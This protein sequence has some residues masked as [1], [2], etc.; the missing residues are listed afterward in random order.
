MV[1]LLTL[2]LHANVQ[3]SYIQRLRDPRQITAYITHRKEAALSS[4]R[5]GSLQEGLTAFYNS[6]DALICSAGSRMNHINFAAVIIASVHVWEAAKSDSN[7]TVWSDLHQR[8][9]QVYWQCIHGLQPLLADTAPQQISTVLWSSATLG[10]NPDDCVPGMVHALMHRFLQLINTTDARQRPNAQ[11]CANLIWAVATMRHPATEVL[12]AACS[13]F[14]SLLRSPIVK[15]HPKAEEV[16]SVVW[17]FGTL[18]QIPLDDALLKDLCAHMLTLL[19]SRDCRI[20]PNAQAISS[21]LWGLAELKHAP[22]HDVGSAMLDHLRALCKTPGWQPTSQAISNSLH[23][24]AEL[25]LDVTRV[26]GEALLNHLLGIPIAQVSDQHYSNVAW[27]LAVM[28]RL[29]LA[30]FDALLSRLSAKHALLVENSGLTTRHAQ[31]K[32]EEACQLHQAL[33]ALKPLQKPNQMEV[34]C[35][36]SL[37]LHKL[38]PQQVPPVMSFSGQTELWAALAMLGVPF[39]ARGLCGMY[40]ADAVISTHDSN[41]AQIILMVDRAEECLANVPSR[42]LLPLLVC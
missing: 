6:M 10:F 5:G 1:L 3:A 16:A 15:Q 11:S 8:I 7:H 35:A 13:H 17:S 19:W 21:M 14:A 33:E 30:I 32:V 23:A 31:P 26:C 4:A 39:K 38:A 2:L 28:G 40:R 20:H 12:A 18:K 34:W 27:S 36:L 29:D 42:Y 41:A 37:R 22:S 9:E 25:R 24:C